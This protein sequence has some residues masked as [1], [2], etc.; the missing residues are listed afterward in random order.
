[1]QKVN[2]EV[3]SAHALPQ[4]V[5]VTRMSVAIVG[6]GNEFYTYRLSILAVFLLNL[7]SIWLY[8]GLLQKDMSKYCCIWTSWFIWVV[9]MYRV[10]I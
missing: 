1:M 2:A 3:G 7:N 10:S 4:I 5:N 6:L 8:S 9:T